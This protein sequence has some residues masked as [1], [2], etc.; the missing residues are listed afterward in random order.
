ME[1]IL[2]E[3]KIQQIENSYS[4]MVVTNDD[5]HLWTVQETMRREREFEVEIFR[6]GAITDVPPRTITDE[7]FDRYEPVEIEGESLS[8]TII[9]E[10]R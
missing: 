5:V 8:D 7:D 1:Q 9:Q 3:P 10:R 4:E 6:E 2:V